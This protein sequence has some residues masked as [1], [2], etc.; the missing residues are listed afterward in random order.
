MSQICRKKSALRFFPTTIPKYPGAEQSMFKFFPFKRI[1]AGG[2]HFRSFQTSLSP[3]RSSH[4]SDPPIEWNNSNCLC[5]GFLNVQSSKFS[6][7][8]RACYKCG[9]SAYCYL[10]F[11]LFLCSLTHCKFSPSH[12]IIVFISILSTSAYAR[13]R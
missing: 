1:L 2:N 6:R 8:N 9:S 13:C 11:L 3:T 4:V 5:L 12:R 7:M 10:F